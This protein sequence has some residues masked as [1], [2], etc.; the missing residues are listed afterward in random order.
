MLI[1]IQGVNLRN[2]FGLVQRFLLLNPLLPAF[3]QERVVALLFC[4]EI[5]FFGSL[6]KG[7]PALLKMKVKMMGLF[8]GLK[9][10]LLYVVQNLGS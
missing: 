5:Q 1:K 4:E 7:Y 2:M 8:Q 9:D 10:G 3:G 6:L